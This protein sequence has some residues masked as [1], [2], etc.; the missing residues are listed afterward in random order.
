MAS[1]ELRAFCVRLA[2]DPESYFA[3]IRYPDA[4]LAE[5]DLDEE[6]KV[7]LL[8]GDPDAIRARMHD[9]EH[10]GDGPPPQIFILHLVPPPPGPEDLSQA[11]GQTFPP[12]FPDA[13]ADAD[14]P[15]GGT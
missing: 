13:N 2:R 9:P 5:S 1:A 3:F 11:S 4:V 12:D 8:S 6:D 14:H 10:P 7:A 15:K